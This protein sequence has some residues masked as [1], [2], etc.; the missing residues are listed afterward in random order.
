MNAML[1]STDSLTQL[2]RNGGIYTWCDLINVVKNLP[3]ERTTNRYDFDLV[4]REQRGT[5]SS[6]HALLKRIADLNRIKNVKLMLA[7]FKMNERNM[8]AIGD[9]L[10]G[11]PIDYIPEAHCYLRISGDPLDVTNMN[12]CYENIAADIIEE[13]EIYPEDIIEFKEQYQRDFIK[14]WIVDENIPLSLDR[15]W[16]LREKCI[17]NMSDYQ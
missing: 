12:S 17:A 1:N 11:E 7:I 9:A 16:Q 4:I 15:I 10:H 8:P 3:Y 14:N 6:K 5:C 2:L 13:Q